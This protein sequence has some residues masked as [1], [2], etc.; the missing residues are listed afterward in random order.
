MNGSVFE[1]I[2]RE[3]GEGKRR[4][5]SKNGKE[6]NFSIFI[7]RFFKFP[8]EEQE[9]ASDEKDV[10]GESYDAAFNKELHKVVVRIITWSSTHTA[11]VLRNDRKGVHPTSK[12]RIAVCDGRIHSVLPELDPPRD[13]AVG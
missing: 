8:E 13:G 1:D 5:N 6:K 11:N 9:N 12:E 10:D 7:F 4:K 2:V 3:T